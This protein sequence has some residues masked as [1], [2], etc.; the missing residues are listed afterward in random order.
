MKKIIMIIILITTNCIKNINNLQIKHKG[1]E[2]DLIKAVKQN[3]IN[4]VNRLI[5]KGA[6]IN[7]VDKYGNTAL[8]FAASH[9]PKEIV[10]LLT[11]RGADI[12]HENKEGSTA[13][14]EAAKEG[15]KEI[16]ELLIERGA[17][18]NHVNKY[19]KT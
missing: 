5:E 12:N 4:E 15:H 6:Y 14:M 7:D 2:E 3:Y 1:N 16:V 8:I 19:G 13:L 17:D 11:E 9:C 18:I 10:K